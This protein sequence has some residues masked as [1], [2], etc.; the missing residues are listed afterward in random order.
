MTDATGRWLDEYAPEADVAEQRVPVDPDED[1]GQ[2]ADPCEPDADGDALKHRRG[3]ADFRRTGAV[4]EQQEC[5]H[6]TTFPMK[7]CHT[8]RTAFQELCPFSSVAAE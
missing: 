1:D 3:D 4:R 7:N 2:A 5:V 6:F 8:I